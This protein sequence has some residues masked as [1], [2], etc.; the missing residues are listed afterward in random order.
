MCYFLGHGN[1][2]PL[3][4]SDGAVDAIAVWALNWMWTEELQLTQ[5]SQKLIWK[6]LL[7][8]TFSS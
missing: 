8:I 1:A 4:L 5:A 2:V 7:F 3:L 6:L